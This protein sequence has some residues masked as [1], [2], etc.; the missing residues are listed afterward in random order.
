MEKFALEK[1]EQVLT[2]AGLSKQ[3]RFEKKQKR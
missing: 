1:L 2:E 3:K